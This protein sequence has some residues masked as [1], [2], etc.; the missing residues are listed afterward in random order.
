MTS[1]TYYN[2]RWESKVYSIYGSIAILLTDSKMINSTDI[3]ST[4]N[5]GDTFYAGTEIDSISGTFSASAGSGTW[6][7]TDAQDDR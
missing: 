3:T 1:Y 6:S 4:V 5:S 2:R 7:T